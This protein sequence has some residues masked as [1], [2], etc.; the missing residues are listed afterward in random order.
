MASSEDIITNQFDPTEH[1]TDVY[2]AFT[3]F[4]ASFQYKYQSWTKEPPLGTQDLT[5]WHQQNKRKYFLGRFASR[6]LQRDFKHL[7]TTEERDTITFNVM[8]TKLKER[9][10][11]TKNTTIRNFQFLAIKQEDGEAF[12]TFVNRVKH[13]A[14]ACNFKCATA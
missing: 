11:P 10:E 9:Y 12:D 5:A 14:A 2:E 8:V 4:V 6:N 13:E 3:E 7:T 1:P